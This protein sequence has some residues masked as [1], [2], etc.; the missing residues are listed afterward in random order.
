[1]TT[2]CSFRAQG[3]PAAANLPCTAPATHSVQD[4]RALPDGKL[5]EPM[6]SCEAH[7][8]G[9]LEANPTAYMITFGYKAAR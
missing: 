8:I 4:R 6:P 1:M 3:G 2:T 7:A 5:R 9:L